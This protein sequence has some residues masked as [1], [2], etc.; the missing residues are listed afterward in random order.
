MFFVDEPFQAV[1][2]LAAVPVLA[3]DPKVVD[4]HPLNVCALLCAAPTVRP[5]PLAFPVT[6]TVF[7]GFDI[8]TS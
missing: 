2:G 1:V 8:C 7:V 5:V 4:V 3:F 6:M